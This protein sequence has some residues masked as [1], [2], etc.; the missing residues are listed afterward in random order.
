MSHAEL[1]EILT[2]L[3]TAGV[4]VVRSIH[5]FADAHMATARLVRPDWKYR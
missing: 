5:S 3:G 1:C 4:L 2:V